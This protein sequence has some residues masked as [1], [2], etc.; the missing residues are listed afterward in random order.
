VIR[1]AAAIALTA[2]A[3]QA[4]RY[5]ELGPTR[6]Q[7][8][9]NAAT[10]DFPFTARADEELTGAAVRLAFAAPI[11]S[12]E[13]LVND[14]RVALLPGG[15]LNPPDMPVARALLADRNTL[16]LRLR[17]REG[18]CL[19][20]PDAWRALRSVGV[21]LQANAVPLPDEL[22]L[23]PLPFFDRGHDTSATVP[24]VLA[25]APSRDE[26]RL[27]ALVASW[28][29][30]DAP[31]PLAFD[32]QLGAL[33]DS[34]AV[35]LL[36][37]DED[38]RRLGIEPLR[39]PSIRM[40]DHP[41]HPDSNVK[42][43]VIG[44]R[45]PD[46]LRTAVESLAARTARLAGQ[47]T[48]LPPAPP[49]PPAAPYAAPRWVPSGGPVPFSKYPADGVFAHEGSTPATLS[50]RFRV[51]PD[52]WVWPAE[53]VVLDL[54]YSEHVARG[55]PPP[56][57]DVEM[58]GYFLATL[59][60][61][62]SDRPERV[63]LRIPRE[64]MRGFNELLVHVHYP[65]PDPCAASV[66]WSPGDR[67]RVTISG[68]SVLHTEGLSHFANLPDVSAFAF[69]GFP[70]TRVADLGETAVVLPDRPSPAELSMALSVFGQLAQ[71]TGKPGSR[72]AFLPPSETPRDKDVLAI[73]T[74]EDNALVARWSAALPIALQ[75]KSARVQ[76]S[77]RP[78]DLLGGIEPLLD[79]NRAGDLLARAGEVAAIAS[80][81]SPVSPGRAAVVITGTAIPRFSDFLGYAQSRGRG[82]DLLVLAGGERAMFRIGGSFGRGKLDAWTR[83]R[84]FLATH[85]LA[86]PPL[87]LAGAGVLAARARRSLS[88]RMRARLALPE[89]AA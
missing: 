26:I 61:P 56:R 47:E 2:G 71:I 40:T 16:S 18:R 78:L 22:A 43:L 6:A 49:Q 55:V 25:H 3:A 89:G 73:G 7:R 33:P 66:P 54:G 65:D 19:A 60:N 5:V 44:G 86:L 52:L 82:G 46:E 14:E 13:V 87:L 1:L 36:D 48:P 83:A 9:S 29:A 45:S 67:P 79:A 42:L 37:S 27:L 21:A 10:L 70:F 81:E 76:R 50:V 30:V 77:L 64:H 11:G 57:L 51:A 88:R 75:G 74:P 84:W 59:P 62:S 4:A 17:D 53:F 85:W 12:L 23:L 8:D 58:N 35:V 20:R 39:G 34:R 41:R 15:D 31:L 63:R 68:D 24:L 32:A 72:A 38:A 28:F 69:D 80:V